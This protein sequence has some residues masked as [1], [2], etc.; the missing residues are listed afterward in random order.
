MLALSKRIGRK[1]FNDTLV[2]LE[3]FRPTN[4]RKEI[5]NRRLEGLPTALVP[6]DFCDHFFDCV[7]SVQAAD[8]LN[9]LTGVRRAEKLPTDA[10][11][12]R[13]HTDSDQSL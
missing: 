5:L 13:R 7:W 4:I 12:V 8:Q 9:N 3:F 6:P 2:S 11:S 1:N 10:V